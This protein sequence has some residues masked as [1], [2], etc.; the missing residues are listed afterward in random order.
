[1]SYY[2]RV[3]KRRPT[4]NRLCCAACEHLADSS[5]RKGSPCSTCYAMLGVGGCRWT[6][7]PTQLALADEPAQAQP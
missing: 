5:R 2:C 4:G 3:C 7:Q 6:E 1:M